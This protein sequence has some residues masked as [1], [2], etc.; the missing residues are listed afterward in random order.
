MREILALCDECFLESLTANELD[1]KPVL[2][3]D[4]LHK[5]Y[6]CNGYKCNNKA[7]VI[8]TFKTERRTGRTRYVKNIQIPNTHCLG[9]LNIIPDND[10]E[11]DELPTCVI[12][13]S[14]LSHRRICE[15]CNLPEEIDIM[16]FTDFAKNAPVHMDCLQTYW[17]AHPERR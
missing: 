17:K 8:A 14:K 10:K 11:N 2:Y 12:C 7:V 3:T 4:N 13:E 15:V 1:E 9:C 5:E 16:R 6:E